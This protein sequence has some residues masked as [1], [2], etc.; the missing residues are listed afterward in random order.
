[1]LTVAGATVAAV[2]QWALAGPAAG[3]ALDV[4]LNGV[5]QHVGAAA[6]VAASLLAGLAAWGLLA[7]LERRSQRAR[8]TWTIVVVAALVLSLAGPLSSAIGTASMLSLIGLHLL[9]AIVLLIGLG[10]SVRG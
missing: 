1:V 9:V 6:V 5:V 3:V 10:R 7:L 8:R 2:A 4:R